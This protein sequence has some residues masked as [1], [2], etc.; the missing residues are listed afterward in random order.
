[1]LPSNLFLLSASIAASTAAKLYVSSYD[2]NITSINVVIPKD[3]S[4]ASQSSLKAYPIAINNGC[5]PSP[6]W[7][8]LHSN[9]LFCGEEGNPTPNISIFASF[10]TTFDG[11]LDLLSKVTTPNGNVN[12]AIFGNGTAIALAE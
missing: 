5:A 1:M 8:R 6:S 3:H 7:L 9:I 10:Q 11:T 12:S 2:G 4:P